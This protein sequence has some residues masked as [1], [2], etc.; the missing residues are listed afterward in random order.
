L[1][2]NANGT[3]PAKATAFYTARGGFGNP[4]LRDIVN[5]VR[6]LTLPSPEVGKPT[7]FGPCLALSTLEEL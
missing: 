5:S 1:N 7:L 3:V 2:L 6:K 4:G